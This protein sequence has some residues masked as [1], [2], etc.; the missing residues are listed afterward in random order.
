MVK[1][2]ISEGAK[3]RRDQGAGVAGADIV[4]DLGVDS[5]DIQIEQGGNIL[6]DA[7]GGCEYLSIGCEHGFLL[8]LPSWRSVIALSFLSDPTIPR[9]II[10]VKLLIVVYNTNRICI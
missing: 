1:E 5:V 3:P 7:V 10:V 2:Q 6:A 9:K 4:V 8:S